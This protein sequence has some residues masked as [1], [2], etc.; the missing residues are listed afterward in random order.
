MGEREHLLLAA[1][2]VGC[3]G[4]KASLECREQFEDACARLL[5]ERGV[6]L[7]QPATEAQV[8]GDRQRAEHTAP[9]GHRHQA[10]LHPLDRIKVCD[11]VALE[12]H[13]P[14][15]G[16][17]EAGDHAQDG[18]LSCAVG[19]EQS[20]HLPLLHLQVDSEQHLDLAVRG[21]DVLARDDQRACRQLCGDLRGRSGR[22][23]FHCCTDLCGTPCLRRIFEHRVFREAGDAETTAGGNRPE[24][25]VA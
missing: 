18:R 1:R 22:T 13:A 19:T 4:F 10:S 6:A 2:Q 7:G 15:L 24:Q 20:Q 23:D 9:T 3:F 25:S 12:D 21:V 16:P 14:L 17:K 5:E 11:V 8:L